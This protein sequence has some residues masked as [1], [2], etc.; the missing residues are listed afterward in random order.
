MAKKLI[1]NADFLGEAKEFLPTWAKEKLAQRTKRK[2]PSVLAKLHD[3]KAEVTTK[4]KPPT[5]DKG[6]DKWLM[7]PFQRP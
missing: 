4:D 6:N 1:F 3:K 7:Y 2:R 5:K